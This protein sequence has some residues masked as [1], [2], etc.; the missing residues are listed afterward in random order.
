MTE[1]KLYYKFTQF[2]T[3][4]SISTH[5]VN[6]WVVIKLLS[7]SKEAVQKKKKKK[8]NT[9]IC[10]SIACI[11]LIVHIIADLFHF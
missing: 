7:Y 4:D 5:C 1:T 10:I 11:L 9:Q 3:I 6:Q 8:K 2:Y